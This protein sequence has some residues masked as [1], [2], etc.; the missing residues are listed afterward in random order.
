MTQSRKQFHVIEESRMTR[1]YLARLLLAVSLVMTG[2]GSQQNKS[3]PSGTQANIT[4][5]SAPGLLP[6]S[7]TESSLEKARR[8][9]EQVTVIISQVKRWKERGHSYKNLSLKVAVANELLPK[10]MISS[11]GAVVNPWGGPVAIDAAPASMG[12]TF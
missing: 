7:S 5:A 1:C 3:Q 12:D 10:E 11:S 9:S 4:P 8:A 2:C 6:T